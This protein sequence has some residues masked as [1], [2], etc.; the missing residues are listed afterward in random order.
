MLFVH[1]P[2][3]GGASVE[4]LLREACPD[5]RT[6]GKQRHARLQRILRHEPG[7]ADYFSFGF[8]RNPWSRMVS[9]YS[10]ID[11][12]NH[13]W[14]PASGRP[15]EGQ[16]GSTRDGNPLWRAVAAYA[17]F[18]E[19]VLRGTAEHDR[20]AMPQVDYLSATTT[21]PT[22]SAA[23]STWPRT[24]PP[25]SAARPAGGRAAAPQRPL[26]R[27]VARLLHPAHPRPDRRGLR[28]G[29]R[30][31]R[32]PLLTGCAAGRLPLV[33]ARIALRCRDECA[34]PTRFGRAPGT[35]QE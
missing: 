13:R 21:G 33:V 34:D 28:Q 31:V 10:M 18:E 30:G 27:V 1:I 17:D 9:W 5:A 4:Q 6:V 14:G 20:L 24:S 22:S 12:W 8:V 3:T 23:P 32:L 15:Q 35:S 7:L 29:R 25:S 19:F 11:T 26:Q 16:W 2:K